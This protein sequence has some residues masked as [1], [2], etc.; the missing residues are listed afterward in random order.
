[1]K[2]TDSNEWIAHR[3]TPSRVGLLQKAVT[4]LG[5]IVFVEL[6]KV[7]QEIK[8]G[9]AVVVIESTKAA[10]DMY[11]PVSGIIV[12]V[13]EA[14]NNQ[15]GLINEDPLGDGWFFEVEMSD[16]KECESLTEYVATE[17]DC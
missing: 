5:D 1:M 14:L 4:Q 3:D 6:P 9:E 12:R 2:K 13:N 11:A 15:P 7:G 10:A 17:C 16:P 8:K